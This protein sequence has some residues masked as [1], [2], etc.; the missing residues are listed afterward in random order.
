MGDMSGIPTVAVTDL[1][2][3][4]VVLDVPGCTICPTSS[5]SP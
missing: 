2:G 4:A 1:P 5:L 3:E